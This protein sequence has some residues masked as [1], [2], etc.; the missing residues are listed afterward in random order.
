MPALEYSAY[1]NFLARR[2]YSVIAVGE[3]KAA[4]GA[5]AAQAQAQSGGYLASG[6][7]SA[8]LALHTRG[9]VDNIRVPH[10]F[11]HPIDTLSFSV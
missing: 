10:R 1:T 11:K 6:K 4:E 7:S 5:E 2:S 8:C 9:V 3:Q